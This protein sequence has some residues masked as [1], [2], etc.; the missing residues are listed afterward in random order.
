MKALLT[1]FKGIWTMISTWK[2]Y[3]PRGFAFIFVLFNVIT[4]FRSE[5][6]GAAFKYLIKV[7][8]ASELI[9]NQNVTLAINNSPE[10]NLFAFFA[11]VNS[12]I[13]LYFLFRVLFW[14]IHFGVGSQLWASLG[15][16]LIMG[17]AEYAAA[18]A[19][20]GGFS[21][22][23]PIIHGVGYLILNIKPV[24]YNINWL[25]WGEPTKGI[26]EGII[27]ETLNIT[28]MTK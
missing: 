22:F 1:I 26:G 25:G 5:G 18:C 20:E 3:I 15:A 10:Y 28:N 4:I 6:L 14:L 11:I 27:N 8:L 12:M 17:F 2:T 16:L 23:I 9:I 21:G 19:F 13:I 7:L 24:L